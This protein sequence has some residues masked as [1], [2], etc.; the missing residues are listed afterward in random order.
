MLIGILGGDAKEESEFK[1]LDDKL[2]EL[3]EASQC[4]LF[5]AAVLSKDPSNC[6]LGYVWASRRGCPVR[7]FDDINIILRKADYCIF[8]LNKKR[9]DLEVKQALMKYKMSGK[10]GS[11]I[12]IG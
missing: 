12:R 5:N 3:I 6:T 1:A 4:F 2:N 11:V 7:Y 9:E 10:H 8:V